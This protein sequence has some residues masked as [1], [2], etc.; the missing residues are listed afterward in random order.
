MHSVFGTVFVTDLANDP[1]TGDIELANLVL[2][3]TE[4][5]VDKDEVIGRDSWRKVSKSNYRD[6]LKGGSYRLRE[7]CA[8]SCLA[9]A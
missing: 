9:V 7:M 4:Y 1:A 3:S 8:L 2:A 6:S 5:D